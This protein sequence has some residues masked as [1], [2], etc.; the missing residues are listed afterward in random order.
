[1]P[2]YLA[3]NI[4]VELSPLWDLA[5]D[6]RWSWC[7]EADSL[8][9][10]VDATQWKQS[11]NPWV[12]L[13]NLSEG[14]LRE[15]AAN[16]N[17]VGELRRV[18]EARR[19]YL[20]SP[21]WFKSESGAT[22]GGV[23]L[24][25]MEF[26]LTEALP[27][28]AGGLGI[29]AGDLLK[30]ASDLGVPIIGI[31][32]LYQ[33]GYFRQM[34][35]AAGWQQEAYPYNE[36]TTMPVEPVL[37]KDGTWVRIGIELPG[38]MLWLRVW[39]AL[40]GR[41]ALYLLDSNDPF[42]SPVDR[43]ITGKL[44]G[45][46]AEM[47]F[48]QEVVLGIGGWRLIERLEPNV[49][50]CHLNEGHAALAVFERARSFAQRSGV[51]F[52]E[53]LW[54][55]RAGNIFT[56][57]TAVPAGFD[58]YPPKLITKYLT[59][60]ADLLHGMGITLPELLRFGRANADDV[61]EPVNVAYLALR[62]SLLA[63]GVSRRH[64]AVS[65]RIFQQLYP[66]WPEPQVP[67]DHVTNGVHVPSWDSQQADEIWTGCCGKDRWRRMPDNLGAS[68]TALSDEALWALRGVTRQAL[69]SSVRERLKGHLSW[70]GLA[71]EIVRQAE[72]VLDPNILTLGFARRFTGY[73]RPNLLLRDVDRLKRLLT[74]P[75]QPAQ[76]L[77]AGKAHP[78]DRQGIE[79]IKEW[80]ECARRPEFR[81]H[82]VFLE[83]Y[84]ISLAQEMVQGVDVWINTP[85]RPWEAC[86]TSGMKVLVN[87]GLNLSELDGWWEEAYEPKL[88]WAI[89]DRSD[90]AGA[91]DADEREADELYTVLERQVIPEFYSRDR[92]GIPRRW[93]ARM[94][95]SM[96][97]LTPAYSS[98]RVVQEYLTKAYLPAAR[99]LRERL[100][101]HVNMAKRMASWERRVRRNWNG[102]HLGPSSVMQAGN[103]WRFAVPVYLGEMN[104]EDIR[105]E[106][107]ADPREDREPEVI[108]L[109]RGEGIA[110]A[111]NGYIYSGLVE[112]DR[113]A[114]DFTARIVPTHPG[115]LVPT[116]V[117]LIL[118]QN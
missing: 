34:I 41:T 79:M 72:G 100:T 104:A 8:W 83:D 89:G 15:L 106:L 23:A 51:S 95:A 45:G 109:A 25:S 48:L 37:G 114:D 71:P 87:G 90:V 107:Y 80:I 44:Y 88:G 111:A 54:A 20:N 73:K 12:I 43:G 118:W 115:V 105:V 64:C 85:R 113:P 22:L 86:G 67:V 74:N 112:S 14:R 17:F 68:I 65:R 42:N 36:P 13:Q 53:G 69:V 3:R 49:E 11:R 50:V 7:H 101:D 94:R 116:E 29:L 77:V 47:R 63:F 24:F 57:H 62:G 78:D 10:N 27:L 81:R 16:V 32:L 5:L 19:A 35:D 103:T 66:R 75:S 56:T 58:R 76:L 117:S 39:R 28:Y 61:D 40:V 9:Q 46:G 93:V 82:V 92:T 96:A 31:G 70:R 91:K 26:G 59:P 84:D 6:L 110:G 108:A 99:T 1:M 97:T 2:P 33:E 30:T 21:C 52:W 60:I 38:R 98:T 102:L 55:T 18:V 4:P